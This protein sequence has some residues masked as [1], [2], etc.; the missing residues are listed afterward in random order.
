MVRDEAAIVL[1]A[2]EEHRCTVGPTVGGDGIDVAVVK[3]PAEV[4]QRCGER[5]YPQETVRRFEEIRG[6]LRRRETGAFQPLGK[7]Y[8]VV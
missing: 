4:C 1:E 6:K 3:V 8:E 7:S 5:L 2:L